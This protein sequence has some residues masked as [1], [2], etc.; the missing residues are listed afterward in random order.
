[1]EENVSQVLAMVC[2][3]AIFQ[4]EILEAKESEKP[5]EAEKLAETEDPQ[6]SRHFSNPPIKGFNLEKD[7]I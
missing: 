4:A 2:R 6:F 1:M 3:I 5:K 7:L